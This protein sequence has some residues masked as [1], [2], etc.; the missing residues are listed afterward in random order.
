[1]TWVD[2]RL[3]FYNIKQDET[4][5]IISLEELNKI[6]LPVIVFANTER[7]QRTTNDDESFATISRMSK[8]VG[9][10]SSISE[11]IDIYKG[12]ENKISMS[13][14]YNIEFFCDEGCSG[15]T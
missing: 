4:M 5:N 13:R 11:D 9:S 7:S 14:I 1:M 10:D 3:D 8:G 6:W 12:S 2:A 15:R